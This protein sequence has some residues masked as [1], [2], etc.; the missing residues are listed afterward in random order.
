MQGRSD[1]QR[2][3][4]DVESV[5]GHLL[6][7]GGVFGFL[8]AHRDEVFPDAMFTDLFPSG[9]GRPSVPAPVVATVLVLQAL[10]GL[11]DREAAEAVTFNLRWKA[12]C[13]LAV[14]APAFHPTTLT[15]W[16]A[17]LARS[18]RPN[19]VFEAVR[20]VVAATG[21][22]RG[23][24]RRAL[25]STVLDDAVAT[26]DTVT[27]LVA[28]VRRVARL[29]P[30]GAELVAAAATRSGHDYSRPGKPEIAWDDTAAR[31]HL[32]DGLVR[33]ARA[34][35]AAVAAA[36]DAGEVVGAGAGAEAVGLLGLVAGQDVELVPDPADPGGPGTWRIA[37]RVAADR[38]IS[39]VDP[40]ARHAHKTSSRRQDGFKAHV[41][42]EPDTG[43]ITACALTKASGEGSGDAAAGIPLLAADTSLPTE[44]PV[45]V[46]GDSA[47]GTGEMLAALQGAGHVPLVK[48]WPV[49]PAVPG[50]FTVDDFTV[51]ADANTLTCP[52]GIT[53]PIN[54]GR[55]VNF[56][57]ACRACPLRARCTRSAT[58]KSMRIREHDALQR[59]HRARAADPEFRALYR[60]HRPMV[61][62]S[63]AWLTRGNR[64]LR[65]IGTTKNNA[66]LHL[67]A[68]A[69]NLRRLT[70]LGLDRDHDTWVLTG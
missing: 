59:A 21:A 64:K 47:Y 54:Q 63:L 42:V 40:Q 3:L 38:V 60:Q 36:E 51:D 68:S 31:A 56:G 24:T 29:L 5:A 16:R 53:R 6:P 37:Q 65:Y 4:L 30:G 66:W 48:P 10:H 14:S 11:S 35:L 7:S 58:G 13:G 25:D 61:E 52:A 69:V 26:Q 20:D 1:P 57:V 32:I 67:R 44:G 17:R 34:V 19:R 27:Q 62:R 9:R 12:A 50:G 28:A 70:A 49:N 23:K 45:E 22:L 39:T 2:E 15:Y 33:D 46:L 18:Q 41:V 55:Q 8:A 43:I